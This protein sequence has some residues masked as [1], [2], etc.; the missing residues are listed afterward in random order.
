[1]SLPTFP[2]EYPKVLADLATLLHRRLGDRLPPGDAAELARAMAEDVRRAWGGSLLYVPRG[3]A[4]DRRQRDAQ[5]WREFNG[6]N[7]AALA[8]RYGLSVPCIY[9]SLAREHARRQGTKV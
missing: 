7:H 3:D 5:I 8:Q 1:M 9:D 4:Y 2:P 6:R